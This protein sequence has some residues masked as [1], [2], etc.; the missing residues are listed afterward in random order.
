MRGGTVSGGGGGLYP[1]C[2]RLPL[3]LLSLPTIPLPRLT[4]PPLVPLATT[5]TFLEQA[6]W[7]QREALT[8]AAVARS[9]LTAVVALPELVPAPPAGRSV[10]EGHGGGG[11]GGLAGG[12]D[13][14][15]AGGGPAVGAASPAARTLVVTGHMYHDGGEEPEV[16]AGWAVRGASWVPGRDGRAGAQAGALACRARG[17]G[18]RAFVLRRSSCDSSTCLLVPFLPSCHAVQVGNSLC[19]FVTL[20][21]T[22]SLDHAT[23]AHAAE[24]L[25]LFGSPAQLAAGAASGTSGAGI[26]GPADDTATA[27][28]HGGA[29]EWPE[30]EGVEVLGWHAPVQGLSAEVVARA[31]ACG[32]LQ[33]VQRLP[34]SAAAAAPRPGGLRLD[35]SALRHQLECPFGLR[36]TWQAA[37]DGEAAMQAA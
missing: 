2:P 16:G 28:Q 24:L 32:A 31:D 11:T 33:T 23:G 36:V 29:V 8:T 21:A 22:F 14:G 12:R 13:V 34:L 30:L 1:C 19:H 20:N 18:S 5:T 4:H 25:L 3:T 37:G 10:R 27:A 7:M 17:S 6:L 26:C 9:P 15:H 35:L